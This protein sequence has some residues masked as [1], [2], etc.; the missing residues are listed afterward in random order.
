WSDHYDDSAANGFQ[1]QDKISA[2]IAGALNV[3]F[4]ALGPSPTVNPKAHDLVLQARAWF[5]LTHYSTLPLTDALP[6]I[7]AEANRALIL[8]PRNVEALLSLGNADSTEG[9]TAQAKAE[10]QRALAL[11]PSNAHAHVAY[12]NALPTRQ[13]LAQEQEAVQLDPDN[14]SAQTDLAVTELDSGQ[15]EQALL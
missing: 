15:Y 7:R 5:D 8:D 4:A 14:A 13:A 10:Y 11:D 1:V 12:G 9:K 2:S 6:Q 3:K